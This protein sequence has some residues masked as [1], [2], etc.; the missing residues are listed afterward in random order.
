MTQ[1]ARLYQIDN[2]HF[3]TATVQRT[4]Q[5]FKFGFPSE[6]TKKSTSTEMLHGL[7]GSHNERIIE[8]VET[9]D[10]QAKDVLVLQD[11]GTA[12]VRQ[13]DTRWLDSTQ[14]RFISSAQADKITKIVIVGSG[15][16][17]Q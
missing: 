5:V 12:Q 17:V 3:Y 6:Y 10:L 8:T 16:N 9:V 15:K 11:F 2:S 1:Q 4:G 13:F 7:W 14:L